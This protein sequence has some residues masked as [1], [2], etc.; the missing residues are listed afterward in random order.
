MMPIVAII[1]LLLCFLCGAVLFEMMRRNR[2]HYDTPRL[3]LALATLC[4]LPCITLALIILVSF[5]ESAT[6]SE[7]IFLIAACSLLGTGG[8]SALI[9]GVRQCRLP[10]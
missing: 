8:L 7:R 5:W 9:W 10:K 3:R 6:P 1:F 2:V 4:A